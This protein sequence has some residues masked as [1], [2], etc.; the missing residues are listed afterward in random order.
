MQLY[1]Y[2]IVTNIHAVKY[3]SS[4]TCCISVSN[5]NDSY[6]ATKM[7]NYFAIT[8]PIMLSERKMRPLALL[9]SK[10]HSSMNIKLNCDIAKTYWME[11]NSTAQ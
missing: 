7:H 9:Y 1:C 2:F 11:D 6:T 4:F 10:H 5:T 3:L 8:T